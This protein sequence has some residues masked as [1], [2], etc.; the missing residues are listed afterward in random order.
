M[1]FVWYCRVK[2]KIFSNKKLDIDITSSIILSIH[3]SVSMS[4]LM[5]L[6]DDSAL[7]ILSSAHHNNH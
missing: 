4:I 7:L 2:A 3:I 5:M 6:T 1:C